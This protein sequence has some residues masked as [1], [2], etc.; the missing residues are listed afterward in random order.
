MYLEDLDFPW[1]FFCLLAEIGSLLRILGW[2]NG[3]CF[4]PLKFSN[5]I[6]GG[7]FPLVVW[8]MFLGDEISSPSS[9]GIL[10]SSPEEGRL[11]RGYDMRS[12]GHALLVDSLGEI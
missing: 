1:C 5:V 6:R 2:L 11:Y 10:S 9:V 7:L 4:F 12:P 8:D 3:V